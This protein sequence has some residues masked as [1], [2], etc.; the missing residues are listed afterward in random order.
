MDRAVR[1]SDAERERALVRL[2]EAMATGRLSDSTF[3]RR[4]DL[5]LRARTRAEL[6]SVLADLPSLGHS[7]RTILTR[8]LPPRRTDSDDPRLRLPSTAEQPIR[9]GR[10]LAVGLRVGHS[11]VSRIHAEL[12][13]YGPG[14]WM[15]RD[16]GSTN[17]TYLNG[18]RITGTTEV[19][20]GDL[21]GFGQATYRVR[22]GR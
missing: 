13:N 8:V 21:I 11:T 5:T 2:R 22:I 19:G 15:V 3:I 16:L 6:S 12:M 4:V 7:V 9:I 18:V 1:V 17:G 10:G 14:R 20:D